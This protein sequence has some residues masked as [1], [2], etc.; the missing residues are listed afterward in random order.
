M[1]DEP[2]RRVRFQCGVSLN[3]EF[4]CKTGDE[5][6]NRRSVSDAAVNDISGRWG[7]VATFLTSG[8]AKRT[9]PP[10]NM[11]F[12]RG[13]PW[14]RTSD[15]RPARRHQPL[16]GVANLFGVNSS[17][18]I[19]WWLWRAIYLS[20]LSEEERPAGVEASV[21]QRS[22]GSLEPESLSIATARCREHVAACVGHGR[23]RASRLSWI[24]WL[25][26][27]GLPGDRERSWAARNVHFAAGRS[28]PE[29][30]S[31]RGSISRAQEA[32][33]LSCLGSVGV[34]LV[35]PHRSIRVARPVEH[36][37]PV[38]ASVPIA[39]VSILL[40]HSS[41][42][43]TERPYAPWV[44]A[45]QEQLEQDVMKTWEPTKL[46]LVSK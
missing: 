1:H 22:G 21:P 41:I 35:C 11:R 34:D 40:G 12:A 3:G 24:R 38:L 10:S 39:R 9:L 16:Y 26:Q 27:A 44:Q 7:T 4:D 33:H 46:Q 19:A 25:G 15:S 6:E 14:L 8:P 37:T 31:R 18:F 36:Y 23:R 43:V 17:G 45:R 20:K 5:P 29:P 42:K 28:E 2:E 32:R 30:E 13:K